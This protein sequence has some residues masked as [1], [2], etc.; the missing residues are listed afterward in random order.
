MNSLKKI[1]TIIFDCDGV[2]FQ[3]GE[4]NRNYYNTLL[5]KFDLP[6]MTEAQFEYAQMHTADQAAEH[7]FDGKIDLELV[8]KERK[9]L[10]YRDFVPYME[11]TKEFMVLLEYL[12]RE[13]YKTGIATNRSN[14]MDLVMDTFGLNEYFDIL[15]TAADVENPKP[16]PEQLHKIKNELN[17]EY[18]NLLY[19]GDSKL[20]QT[21]AKSAG[22]MFMAFGNK[23]LEASYHV[24]EMA[25]IIKL[26]EK[27]K[28]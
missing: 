27:A 11:M 20:D 2:M 23:N 13:N 10:P 24:N 18:E 16:H 5:A 3:T 1:N 22:V 14:T 15:V 28:A 7:I 9:K 4:L 25:E 19:V 17:V 21:A 8:F 6:E 12:K 26:L